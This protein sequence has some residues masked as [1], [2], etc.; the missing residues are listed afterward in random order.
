MNAIRGVIKAMPFTGVMLLLGVFA[1]TGFPPFALFISEFLII[2]GGFLKGAYFVT[3]CLLLLIAVIFAAFIYHFGKMLFGNLP[4]GMVVMGEPLSGKIAF[5]FLFIQVSAL[6][7][8]LPFIKKDLIWIA[9]K[10]FQG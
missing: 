4:K 9:Q 1:I 10:L 2:V 6:G 5:L 7:I 3:A 8:A